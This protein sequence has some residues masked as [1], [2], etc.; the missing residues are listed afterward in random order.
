MAA[1]E[2]P[3]WAL[4]SQDRGISGV[5]APAGSKVCL[6]EG[7]TGKQQLQQEQMDP[8]ALRKA[9]ECWRLRAGAAGVGSASCASA[10][11]LPDPGTGRV[12]SQFLRSRKGF[13]FLGFQ[14]RG[15]GTCPGSPAQ[16]G[17]VPLW[18]QE[19][20]SNPLE[21]STGRIPLGWKF[22]FACR[23]FLREL[24]GPRAGSLCNGHICFVAK[25]FISVTLSLSGLISVSWCLP[26]AG[27]FC[28]G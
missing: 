25:L 8:V 24:F 6:G 28:R 3:G 13:I 7:I 12:M 18:N 16:V 2:V 14:R 17:Q 19:N 15:A 27:S 22:P 23:L 21:T 11:L 1:L 9:L 4:L 26:G 20:V 5:P 10:R